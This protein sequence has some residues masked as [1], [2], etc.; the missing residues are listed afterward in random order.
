MEEL[1]SI[2]SQFAELESN[3]AKL[4]KLYVGHE[5][6]ALLEARRLVARAQRLIHE[7]V[8]ADA[9]GASPTIHTPKRTTRQYRV[10]LLGHNDKI[11]GSRDLDAT[12]DEEAIA[13]AYALKLPCKCE[14]WERVRVLA[15]LQPYRA[16]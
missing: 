9:R 14:V 13:A 15:Q 8:S 4:A 10:F 12:D 5:H 6:Q 7:H 11:T 16:P 3:L 2:Q 1:L